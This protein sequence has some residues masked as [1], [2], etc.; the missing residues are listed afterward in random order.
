MDEHDP[1]RSELCREPASGSDDAAAAAASSAPPGTHVVLRT[2]GGF[3]GFGLMD[4][5]LVVAEV[6]T[7]PPAIHW[8]DAAGC[9]PWRGEDPALQAAL[10]T[11][12]ELNDPSSRE[13]ARQRLSAVHAKALL[14]DFAQL[15]E[16]RTDYSWPQL[17]WLL[18]RLFRLGGVLDIK[19][20]I[21]APDLACAQILSELRAAAAGS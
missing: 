17:T 8:E 18:E 19:A 11:L 20:P 9:D 1:R 21:V 3:W 5:E 2:D 15:P 7:D 12:L 6:S 13:R 10:R 14:Y 4:G 16:G